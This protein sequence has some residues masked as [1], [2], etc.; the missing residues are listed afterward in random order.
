[1]LVAEAMPPER[2]VPVLHYDGTPSPRVGFI[3]DAVAQVGTSG[4]P[5]EK[6]APTGEPR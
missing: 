3:H 6:P 4:S 2:L 5:L 1:V